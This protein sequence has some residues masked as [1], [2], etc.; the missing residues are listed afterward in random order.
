MVVVSP[1]FRLAWLC[2]RA[3]GPCCP[4]A[5][6]LTGFDCSSVGALGCPVGPRCAP[7]I[8]LNVHVGRPLLAGR[9]LR[10]G[11]GCTPFCTIVDL[12]RPGLRFAPTLSCAPVRVSLLQVEYCAVAVVGRLRASGS[13]GPE[14]FPKH[15][16]PEQPGGLAR[17][18][19][20][21]IGVRS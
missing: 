6:R 15:F 21:F 14:C 18:L 17:S 2:V 16:G 19:W 5:R 10:A 12:V 20:S 7:S 1:P 4:V 13:R 11:F 8:V 9:I 3:A